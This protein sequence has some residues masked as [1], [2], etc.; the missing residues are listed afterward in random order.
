MP[1]VQK[2][3]VPEVVD[4]LGDRLDHGGVPRESIATGRT[5]VVK[6]RAR[7]DATR[8][9]W[10]DGR[11]VPLPRSVAD[12]LGQHGLGSGGV[13]VVIETES[14]DPSQLVEGLVLMIVDLA[15]PDPP[16]RAEECRRAAAALGLERLAD[17]GPDA[18]LR[19]D[20]EVLKARTR[21]VITETA[22]VRAA[23]RA[24]DS[25][26]WAQVG[27]ILTASH[28]SLR[29]DFAASRA[30]ADVAA[31]AA[32]EAGALG[33]RMNLALVPADRVAAVRDL[34]ERRFEDLGWPRPE[35]QTLGVA[36]R[37]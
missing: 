10:A 3:L 29:D 34:V 5:L 9:A 8:N 13:D 14:A 21:H 6:A 32:L 30:E 15:M 37:P 18:V 7:D 17:A 25:A 11:R 22:R 19:L 23:R 27:S 35:V 12:S 31:D 24:I 2:W 28:T 26:A 4:L 20:D 16:D 33:V 36:K 1:D